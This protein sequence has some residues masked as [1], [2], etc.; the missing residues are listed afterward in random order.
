MKGTHKSNEQ[1]KQQGAVIS[2]Y[3]SGKS[4]KASEI[5]DRFAIASQL[6]P[7]WAKVTLHFIE[8]QM[9]NDRP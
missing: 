4:V 8:T 2:R 7:G 6:A 9:V 5:Y 1:V 3:T